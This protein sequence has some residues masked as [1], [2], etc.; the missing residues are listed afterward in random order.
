MLSSILHRRYIIILLLGFASGVPLA[1]SGSTLFIWLTEEGVDLGTVGLFAALGTPYVLKFLWSPLVDHMELPVLMS[2]LGRRRAWI[3]FSQIFLIVGVWALGQTHPASTPFIAA[4]CALLVAFF[5]ATQDIAIDA[6]R[7][8]SFKKDEQAI[9]VAAYIYGYRAGMLAS[10]AGALYVASSHS[11]GFTYVFMSG[12]L[13]VGI[14]AVLLAKEPLLDEPRLVQDSIRDWIKRAV[15]AP[16]SDFLRRSFWPLILIFI[17][18]FKLGDALAGVM[19][20]PFL[21]EMGFS[22]IEIANIVKFMG[23]AATL[24][25]L[26][27]GGL[28]MV[29][30]GLFRSLLFSGLCQLVSNLM[31][32]ALAHAGHNLGLLATT[33]AIENF[34]AGMGTAVFTAYL[35]LLCNIRFTATQYALFSSF[36][37]LPRTLFSAP[38]GYMASTFGWAPFFLITAFAALPGLLLILCLG[39]LQSRQTKKIFFSNFGL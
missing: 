10:G 15:L 29:K 4:A 21:L 11:W 22:K 17:L 35:S 8:E 14:A 1:L 13:F 20:N 7:I 18:L 26:G 37:A 19:T 30:A 39:W 27:T 16:L 33:I 3:F 28:L 31:F 36:A 34:A 25:G 6:F 32:V 24:V 38:A 2:L 5:S 23:T 12:L 9:A